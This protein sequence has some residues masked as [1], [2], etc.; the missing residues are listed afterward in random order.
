MK[1]LNVVLLSLFFI[2]PAFSFGK[3]KGASEKPR[4]DQ[5]IRTV[6]RK[7]APFWLQDAETTV[8]IKKDGNFGIDA[9]AGAITIEG[10]WRVEKGQL[11]LIWNSDKHEKAYPV[12]I[13]NHQAIISG[14]TEQDGKYVLTGP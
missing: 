2:V 10:K 9:S 12:A 7:K 11:K 3:S 13:E 1:T 14:A 6:I 5:E 4:S 8:Q